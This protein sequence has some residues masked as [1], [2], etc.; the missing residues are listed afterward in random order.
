M[1]CMIRHYRKQKGM[2]QKDLA[3]VIGRSRSIIA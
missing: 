1:K 3:D 2:T